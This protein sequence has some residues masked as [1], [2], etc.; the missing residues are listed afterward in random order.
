MNFSSSAIERGRTAHRTPPVPQR[1]SPTPGIFLEKFSAYDDFPWRTIEQF[2]KKKWPHWDKFRPTRVRDCTLNVRSG[3][4]ALIT[5]SGVH[6]HFEVPER[7]TEVR[8]ISG[9][10]KYSHLELMSCRQILALCAS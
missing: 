4:D 5:Q 9:C 1:A 8:T 10:E 7:L 6:W 3:A 2:L